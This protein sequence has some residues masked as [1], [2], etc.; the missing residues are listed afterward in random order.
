MI[1]PAVCTCCKQRQ[2]LHTPRHS[3]PQSADAPE[4][5]HAGTDGVIG[6]QQLGF[7]G[8]PLA[9][10]QQHGI[11]ISGLR[12]MLSTATETRIAVYRLINMEPNQ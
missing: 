12:A 10:L 3:P 2:V 9:D 8:P 7:T 11:R 6:A 4:A 5:Q 1:N